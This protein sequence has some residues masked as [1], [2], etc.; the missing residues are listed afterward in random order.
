MS[1]VSQEN[2]EQD[3]CVDGPVYEVTPQGF[4]WYKHTNNE[5]QRVMLTNWTAKIVGDILEDNGVETFRFFAIEWIGNELT[6][7]QVKVNLDALGYLLSVYTVS[8]TG[9]LKARKQGGEALLAVQDVLNRLGCVVTQFNLTDPPVCLNIVVCLPEKERTNWKV[10]ID[11]IQ[12]ADDLRKL[13]D[14]LSLKIWDSDL[15]IANA[16]HQ[17]VEAHCLGLDLS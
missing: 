6:L 8:D 14:K 11:T 9:L 10:L 1:E 5:V 4:V 7:I 17:R 12:K 2:Q 15:A 16:E 3:I 13:P